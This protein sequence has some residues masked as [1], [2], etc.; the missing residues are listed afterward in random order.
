MKVGI[1]QV[2]ARAATTIRG[3]HADS[4]WSLSLIVFLIV[5]S[6]LCLVLPAP[7]AFGDDNDH[8]S[9]GQASRDGI[10][11]FYMGRE[12]GHV[13]GHRG[14]NWLERPERVRE[15]RT[16][17]LLELLGLQPGHTVADIGAGTGYFAL[18][19]ADIVGETG[20]VL[21]VDIQPEMLAII[22]RRARDQARSNVTPLLATEQN[23]GLPRGAVDVVLLVDAYH[24][25]SHPREVMRK[26]VNSLTPNGRVV[27]VEYRGED[28][29]VPIK[30]LHKMTVAQATREMAAVGLELQKVHGDLPWQHVMVFQLSNNAPARP[31]PQTVEPGA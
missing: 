5:M 14:A 4:A 16:D 25:F 28:R 10:G 24:E 20:T 30:P 29:S 13:M 8:Y 2:A 21:A 6:A 31:A 23:P 22:E 9:H 1:Y 27:L 18:P 11:K 17:L 7:P 12:I 26:V 15:E 3:Q 19:M